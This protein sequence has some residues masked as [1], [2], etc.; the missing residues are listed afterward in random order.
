M[1]E[2]K[3]ILDSMPEE[4]LIDNISPFLSFE[5]VGNLSQSS[6]SSNN[7]GK[8]MMGGVLRLK[9]KR[10]SDPIGLLK[11]IVALCKNE[12]RESINIIS[13]DFSKYMNYVG[14]FGK[15]LEYVL[16]NI[17]RVKHIHLPGNIT[18]EERTCLQKMKLTSLSLNLNLF[19]K[20]LDHKILSPLEGLP[21]TSLRLDLDGREFNNEILSYLKGLPLTSLHLENCD[22]VTDEVVEFKGLPLTSLSLHGTEFNNEILSSLKGLPLTSLHVDDSTYVTDEGIKFLQ[23]MPLTSLNLMG[24]NVTNEGIKFLQGMPL[25]SLNLMGTNV[26]NEGIKFLQGMPL[27]SLNLEDCSDV[28]DIGIEYLKGLPLTSLNLIDT[29]VTDEGIKFLK[30]L[31]LTSLSLYC[32]HNVT[33]D[34]LSHLKD[35][36]LRN[37]YIQSDEALTYEGLAQLQNL[38]LLRRL[39]LFEFNE[40]LDVGLFYFQQQLIEGNI[41]IITHDNESDCFL[42]DIKRIRRGQEL[43]PKSS[44]LIF[45][46]KNNL[47]K[48][49]SFILENA[50]NLDINLIVRKENVVESAFLASRLVKNEEMENNLLVSGFNTNT[51]GKSY[52]RAILQQKEILRDKIFSSFNNFFR[53]EESEESDLEPLKKEFGEY[54]VKFVLND[55]QPGESIYPHED[56]IRWGSVDPFEEP[57]RWRWGSIDRL[58]TRNG[59][60]NSKERK[61]PSSKVEAKSAKRQA[62]TSGLSV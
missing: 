21:L 16:H 8:K 1:K 2:Q 6:K 58:N 59:L 11:N 42:E 34:G 29:G 10:V 28:G 31:P 37:L 57:N 38:P 3:R 15:M 62:T 39:V 7:L 41:D 45:A 56:K 23:G 18:P 20:E 19:N 26:T 13:L 27:T 30:G 48:L 50:K 33:D 40:I 49:S 22:G 36:P 12:D 51:H 46:I 35:L 5:D 14:F 55:R 61:I 44:C 9:L 25:T 43:E 24:T 17:P 32:H 47:N 4:L 53:N 54:I 60:T 52:G